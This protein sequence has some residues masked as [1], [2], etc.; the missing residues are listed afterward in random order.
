LTS[1]AFKPNRRS[2]TF[3][4]ARSDRIGSIPGSGRKVI[5]KVGRGS[6]AIISAIAAI[7]LPLVKT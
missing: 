4:A 7:G 1:T 6:I 2:N 3:N 5:T